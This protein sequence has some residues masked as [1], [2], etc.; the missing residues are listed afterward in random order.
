MCEG[1]SVEVIII[2]I[3]R[4]KVTEIER[5]KKGATLESVA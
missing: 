5:H 2:K 3:G 4:E 1:W